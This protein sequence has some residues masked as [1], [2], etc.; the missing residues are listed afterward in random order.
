MALEP[1][2]HLDGDAYDVVPRQGPQCRQ[3]P[4]EDLG[5]GQENCRDML[6]MG[7]EGGREWGRE[8]R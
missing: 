3:A 8:E 2:A 4:I 7:V 5:Q 6:C 1:L